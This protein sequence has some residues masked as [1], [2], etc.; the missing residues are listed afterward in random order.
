MLNIRPESLPGWQAFNLEYR[1]Y[2]VHSFPENGLMLEPHLISD[3]LAQVVFICIT[4]TRVIFTLYFS[5]VQLSV[6]GSFG[7]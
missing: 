7:V 4:F 6:C 5:S 1:A 3:T 2:C